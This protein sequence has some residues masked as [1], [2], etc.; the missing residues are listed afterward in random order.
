MIAALAGG[1]GGARLLRGL[2]SVAPDTVAVVNTGD[3]F[4]L[5]GLY[6]CPDID[7]ILY[8]LSGEANLDVGWGMRDETWTAMSELERRGGEAWFRLGDR[9][10]ATHMFRTQ[11]LSVGASLTQVTAELAAS[12][13]LRNTVLP[14][15]NDP[16]RT[17]I[18]LA[19]SLEEIGFQDYFVRLRHDVPIEAVRFDGVTAASPTPEVLDALDTAERIVICPSNPFVSIAPILALPQ[20]TEILRRRRASVVAVSPIIGGAAVKGPAG[21]MLSELG[22]DV[23][24]RA[25]ANL[26]ADVAGAFVIDR[27]DADQLDAIEALGMHAVVTDTLMVDQDASEQLAKSVLAIE[28]ADQ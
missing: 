22:H 24:A 19:G 13:G 27:A 23:S 17:M 16:V 3:D 20:I 5:H 26:W 9:D 4:E 10:L 8:T 15:S 14:M 21:R 25:V 28:A 2:F 11:R 6:I 1:V 7:T 12:F 18:Q